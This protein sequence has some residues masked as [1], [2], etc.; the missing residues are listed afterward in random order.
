MKSSGSTLSKTH[1][2]VNNDKKPIFKCDLCPKEYTILMRLHRHKN[3]HRDGRVLLSKFIK[4]RERSIKQRGEY[5]CEICQQVLPYHLDL[6]KHKKIKHEEPDLDCKFCEQK[7]HFNTDLIVHTRKHTGERP[8]KCSLCIKSYRSRRS[9]R[10]HMKT[11][12]NVTSDEK[13]HLCSICKKKFSQSGALSIHMANHTRDKSYPCSKCDKVFLSKEYLLQKH[14]QLHLEYEPLKCNVCGFE[15]RYK[16][17]LQTHIK[18]V[19]ENSSRKIFKCEYCETSLS[20]KDYLI[21]HMKTIHIKERSY[22]CSICEFQTNHGSS[23]KKHNDLAHDSIQLNCNMCEWKGNRAKLTNH[24]KVAHTTVSV[25]VKE[26]KC[27][28]CE[29]AYFRKEHLKKHNERA[30]L[31]VRY[32]CQL[33]DDNFVNNYSLRIHITSK[34]NKVKVLCPQ[35]NH[36]AYDKPSL[37][38]HIKS[39][40]LGLTPYS[41]RSCDHKSASKNNLTKHEKNLH[42][43][44]NSQ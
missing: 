32:Q 11:H 34:H 5:Q 29:K 2:S 23:L 43:S 33:C 24:K 12:R 40:H 30:H 18:R 21:Y 19:H 15:T 7:F 20:S 27:D 10:S 38:K 16:N 31:G 4:P 35:C 26:Y 6:I 17:Y 9:L 41:C 14:E 36:K 39:I 42:R 25:K 37:A 44:V 8:F 28:R 22:S 13:Q 1:L 3:D